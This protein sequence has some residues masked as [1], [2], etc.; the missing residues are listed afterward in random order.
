MSELKRATA[1]AREQLNED[2]NKLSLI[3]KVRE[4][5]NNNKIPYAALI[6]F[7]D[8]EPYL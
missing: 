4:Y 6:S 5:F 3:D 1:W 8:L 2:F 7:K